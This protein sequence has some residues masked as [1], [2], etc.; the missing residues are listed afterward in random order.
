MSNG[1]YLSCY[2]CQQE[3][4]LDKIGWQFALN[5]MTHPQLPFY[6]EID[7][8]PLDYEEW[9]VGNPQ[10]VEWV[11]NE[12]RTFL[13]EHQG[14]LIY[15]RSDDQLC[16]YDNY[17][18]SPINL[19][20]EGQKLGTYPSWLTA[21]A[22]EPRTN[23]LAFGG[24]DGMIRIWDHHLN[25]I[26]QELRGHNDWISTLH[27]SR[28]RERLI[29]TSGDCQVKFWQTTTG[30][31]I[32]SFLAASTYSED[33]VSN[34]VTSAV[35]IPPEKYLITCERN[36]NQLTIWNLDNLESEGQSTSRQYGG[37]KIAIHPRGFECS[38]FPLH[39]PMAYSP[40][41][42]YLGITTYEKER[43]Q[44]KL[45]VKIIELKSHKEIKEVIFSTCYR[46]QTSQ[47][48]FSPDSRYLVCGLE[49]IELSE[50]E[51]ETRVI[52]DLYWSNQHLIKIYD[53]ETGRIV[54]TLTGHSAMI[55][56]LAF[57][58][59][60]TQLASG[61]YDGNLICW[62]LNLPTA[63]Q[64]LSPI[65][66][67]TRIIKGFKV[68]SFQP[69]PETKIWEIELLVEPLEQ[70]EEREENAHQSPL[71]PKTATSQVKLTSQL[72]AQLFPYQERK[73]YAKLHW[74]QADRA[75]EEED[76]STAFKN[77]DQAIQWD[78]GI[79][80][81]M[82]YEPRT[83]SHYYGRY[84]R[85]QGLQRAI[86][87]YK[88]S[89]K[90]QED[91][92]L[93]IS[94]YLFSIQSFLSYIPLTEVEQKI[95]ESLENIEED[96]QSRQSFSQLGISYALQGQWQLALDNLE[97]YHQ[98]GKTRSSFIDSIINF[99]KEIEHLEP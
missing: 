53:L 38:I 48:I 37:T 88:S 59:R 66:S 79:A 81:D 34:Q 56:G 75:F 57:N 26:T 1:C 9:D 25:Q 85:R 82:I 27:F 45:V 84:N 6:L 42:Q 4:Y 94:N 15:I 74:Q 95:N 76:M 47:I 5:G 93:V 67:E 19:S 86:N 83:F 33:G 18:E 55:G 50:R 28:N 61:D 77:W 91:A 54:K 35:L 65:T 62:E 70:S 89:E 23:N 20:S 41:G 80:E 44:Q 21:L 72:L 12:V 52:P 96:P 40:D 43:R 46:N 78:Q 13:A 68:S 64:K 39:Y 63:S 51:R 32:K 73:K 22:F 10:L 60:G 8:I 24:G 92:H 31:N 98:M 11:K 36:T 17:Q 69:H 7:T 16:T 71:S 30:E 99:I 29:S 3:V 14:H 97:I 49:E 90:S 87:Q 58:E 2:N